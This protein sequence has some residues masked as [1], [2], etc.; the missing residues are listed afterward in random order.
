MKFEVIVLAAGQSRRFGQANKLLALVGGVP[1]TVGVVRQM[2]QVRVSGQAAGITVVTST[3]NDDIVRALAKAGLSDDVQI[4]PNSRALDGMGT[5]VAAGIT[6]LAASVDAAVIVPGDM[7]FVGAP[8]IE[9]LFAA[10][11]AG[12]AQQPVHPVLPDGTQTNPVVWP[13]AYFD[14]LAALD[15][16]RGGKSLLTGANARTITLKDPMEAADIDTPEDLS[17]LAES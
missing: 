1:L 14:R 6:N 16:D 8:L 15:G 3:E 17:R 13:R 12:G 11:I 7:P 9:K 4:V 10:F 5:S 2:T